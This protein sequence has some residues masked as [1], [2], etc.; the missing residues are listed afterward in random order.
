MLAELPP[1]VTDVGAL[2]ASIAAVLG[3]VALL[4]GWVR[5]AFRAEVEQ[6]VDG[7]LAPIRDQLRPN[8][9]SSLRDRVDSCA[10]EIAELR[11]LRDLDDRDRATRQEVLDGQLSRIE[12]RLEDGDERMDVMAAALAQLG[13]RPVQHRPFPTGE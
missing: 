9:G 13:A 11:R 10:G 7:Q 12:K 5:R 4:L 6:I 8:G 1:L 3:L 2:A